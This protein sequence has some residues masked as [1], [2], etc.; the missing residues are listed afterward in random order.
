M[1]RLHRIS[2]GVFIVLIC[3]SCFQQIDKKFSTKATIFLVNETDKIIKS[4]ERLNYTIQPG[5]TLIHKESNVLDGDRPTIDQYFLSF[6]ENM[7]VFKYDDN[8]C[9]EKIRALEFYENRKE[10]AP[11]EFEFTFRFTEERKAS[12][13]PCN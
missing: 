11:L 6:L 4:N 5:D 3:S 13:V 10:I 2:I 12:G 7:D 8:T 1:N 9:E